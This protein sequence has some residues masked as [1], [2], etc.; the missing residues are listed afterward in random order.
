MALFGPD[1]TF[2]R[3]LW[4][5]APDAESYRPPG[6]SM[7]NR[8]VRVPLPF[9]RRRYTASDGEVLVV[10]NSDSAMFRTFP[11]SGQAGTVVRWTREERALSS[12]ERDRRIDILISSVPGSGREEVRRLMMQAPSGE[13]P[14][15]GGIAM[16]PGGE[17]WVA[18]YEYL[19]NLPTRWRMF[20][21]SRLVG[22]L[23]TP[24]SF[25]IQSVRGAL[26]AGIWRD[27]FEVQHVRVY[28]MECFNP[29]NS[30]SWR[31]SSS[32]RPELRYV[33]GRFRVSVKT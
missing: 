3:M 11:I 25:S 27:E 24:A 19:L 14:Q 30:A 21:D 17:V 20:S 8:V 9:G 31:S 7:G 22:Y 4:E 32:S 29:S 2:E 10:A 33:S 18:G 28:G 1:S 6:I 16:G 26:V 13:V 12:V 23:E 5:L 15:L